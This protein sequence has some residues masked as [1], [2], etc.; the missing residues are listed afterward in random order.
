VQILADDMTLNGMA[1][2]KLQSPFRGTLDP[3]K[4]QQLGRAR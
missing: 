2:C 3:G 1:C 4:K